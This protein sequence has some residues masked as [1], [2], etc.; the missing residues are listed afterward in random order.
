M[1][2]ATL[3]LATPLVGLCRKPGW[4][5][6]RVFPPA[7][8]SIHNTRSQIS[9]QIGASIG[10]SPPAQQSPPSTNACPFDLGEGIMSPPPPPRYDP[11]YGLGSSFR[12]Y[13]YL[14][15]WQSNHLSCPPFF[16]SVRLFGVF[17]WQTD[18]PATSPPP[19]KKSP[20]PPP[21]T[22]I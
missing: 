9:L 12:V 2:P 22:I 20:H 11:G 5:A 3:F 14:G 18:S 10:G 16:K 8:R 7:M 19:P 4:R 17:V 6:L 1:K 15:R 13:F 21:K